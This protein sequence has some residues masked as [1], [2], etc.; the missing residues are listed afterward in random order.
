M[1]PEL[2]FGWRKKSGCPSRVVVPFRAV[3]ALT[4]WM[5][6]TNRRWLMRREHDEPARKSF[7]DTL[8]SPRRP[9]PLEKQVAVTSREAHHKD[10]RL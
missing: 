7:S 6:G 8:L 5:L 10:A 3:P 9:H 1:K 4:V 2:V